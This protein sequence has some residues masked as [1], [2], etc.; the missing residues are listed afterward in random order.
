MN[1][2]LVHLY[3]HRVVFRFGFWH[4]DVFRLPLYT[5][6]QGLFKEKLNIDV[7]S[8]D[9]F[10]FLPHTQC[11]GI[12]S[13]YTEFVLYATPGFHNFNLRILNLRIPNPN[14]LIECFF[15]T[16]SDFNVPESRPKKITMKFRKLTVCLGLGRGI[17][18][19]L[20]IYKNSL[21][22][23]FVYNSK[24][25]LVKRNNYGLY[26]HSANF[27]IRV[28]IIISRGVAAT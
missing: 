16:M 10:I 12:L 1:I 4:R 23:T 11:L 8:K 20:D 19:F 14:K 7:W 21:P 25:L 24:K 6:M 15:D 18:R 5:R 26:L 27:G 28:S 9:T 13:D 2:K 3:F 22:H 17:L